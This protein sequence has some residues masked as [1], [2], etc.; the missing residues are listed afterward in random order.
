MGKNKFIYPNQQ[1]NPE[2]PMHRNNLK[3][4]VPLQY[5]PTATVICGTKIEPHNKTIQTPMKNLLY[6]GQF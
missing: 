1:P 6:V 4:F 5:T 3:I 2:T